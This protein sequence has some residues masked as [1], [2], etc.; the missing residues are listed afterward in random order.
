MNERLTSYL[1]NQQYTRNEATYASGLEEIQERF[2]Q[3]L[4]ENGTMMDLGCGSGRNT[5]YFSKRGLR[6]TPVEGSRILSDIATRNTGIK[7]RRMM[8]QEL[9]DVDEYYGVWAGSSV[10]HFPYEQLVDVLRRIHKALKKD[11]VLYLS[12][13]YGYFEGVRNG[14]HVL[15]M[16]ETKFG[17]LLAK[18]EGFEIKEM[19]ITSDERPNC[20]KQ[21]WMN[22][23]LSRID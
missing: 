5:I 20:Q 15:D 19:F 22:V 2:V 6:V 18:I 10:L 7:V 9:T 14:R 16:D 1:E 8:F 12:F 4:P 13:K 23:F 17:K 11:G 21:Q 3:L